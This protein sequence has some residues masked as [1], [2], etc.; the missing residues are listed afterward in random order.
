[1]IT[2]SNASPGIP[3]G[4]TFVEV[5]SFVI[6]VKAT[7]I[8]LHRT[9]QVTIA[10]MTILEIVVHMMADQ[11]LSAAKHHLTVHS[12]RIPLRRVIL[13]ASFAL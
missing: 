4:N 12:S 13:W 8:V 6:P 11:Q 10:F 2:G 7:Q 3:R 5:F 1:M 9:A